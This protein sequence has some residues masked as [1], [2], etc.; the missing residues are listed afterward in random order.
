MKS[1]SIRYQP[2]PR[3]TVE[4]YVCKLPKDPTKISSYV[5]STPRGSLMLSPHAPPSMSFQDAMKLR[6]RAQEHF[7]QGVYICRSP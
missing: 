6:A 1:N 4:Y 3:V 5:V 2:R 7:G